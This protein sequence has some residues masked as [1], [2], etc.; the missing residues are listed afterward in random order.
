MRR[1]FGV[2][3]R[4]K[5]ERL[6]KEDSSF[7][8]RRVASRIGV[9]PSFLSRVERGLEPPPSGAKITALAATL[10]ED[11]DVL[12]AIAGKVSIDLQ[13]AI[14]KRP[15]L[16]AQLIRKLKDKPDCTVLNLMRKVRNRKS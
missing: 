15:Q 3:I 2:V 16:F 8:V 9:E 12:L 6:L 13:E 14:L 5:R 10:G 7:S 4:K 11:P 1:S